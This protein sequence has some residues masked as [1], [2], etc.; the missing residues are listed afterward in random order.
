MAI[1]RAQ[2][3]GEAPIAGASPWKIEFGALVVRLRRLAV[4]ALAALLHGLFARFLKL[5]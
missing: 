2:K 4:A 3:K 1:A 5:L